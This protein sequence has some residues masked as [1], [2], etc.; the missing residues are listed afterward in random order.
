MHVSGETAWLYDTHKKWKGNIL[1]VWE[2]S[3]LHTPGCGI[4]GINEGDWK[5]KAVFEVQGN[6]IHFPPNLSKYQGLKKVFIFIVIYYRFLLTL[7]SLSWEDF[8]SVFSK[9]KWFIL[10]KNLKIDNYLQLK[11]TV[12]SRLISLY[13]N[14]KS[15]TVKEADSRNWSRMQQV[16]LWPALKWSIKLLNW[17]FTK[18]HLWVSQSHRSR[19]R[20]LVLCG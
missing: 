13:T 17:P 6:S 3:K 11:G 16:V 1:N 8:Q 2:I 20:I 19:N 9:F 14:T 15:K 7:Q 4:Y 18:F 10:F 12:E 5:R